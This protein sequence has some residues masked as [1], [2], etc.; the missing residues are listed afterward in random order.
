MLTSLHLSATTTP[1]PFFDYCLEN[2]LT[3][4]IVPNADIADGH[5]LP[6]PL[7]P[8][9][10]ALRNNGGYAGHE[11]I[12][13][14]AD[15]ETESLFFVF[16]HSTVRGMSQGGTRM[17]SYDSMQDLL[18][19]G[20][21]LSRAMTEKNAVAEIW[22]GG[23]KS[24]ICPLNGL[25]E[26]GSEQKKRIF[27]QFGSFVAALNGAYVAAEDM[28]TTPE[29]MHSILTRNRFVTCLP[30]RVGGSSNP[31]PWTAKG[32]FYAMKAAVKFRE[33]KNDLSGLTVL[34]QGVGN[35]GLSLAKHCAEAG[36]H[37]LA[38]DPNPRAQA[39]LKEAVPS[40]EIIDL[41]AVADTPCDI[42]APS[43]RGGVIDS[44]VAQR[45]QCRY[46]IGAA[47]NQLIQDTLQSAELAARD[48]LYLP[49]FYVNRMGIVNCAN[50]QYGYLEEDLQQAVDKIYSDTLQLL[51][52][53]REQRK[54]PYELAILEAKRLG[55]VPHPIWGHRGKR[56]LQKLISA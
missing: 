17:L 40:A 53:C 36:A 18:F 30:V 42:F 35:V 23:G 46:V 5:S 37:I 29:D 11:A 20:L 7:I 12:C 8:V 43:A 15:A 38:A 22:W 6:E 21:R 41:Q 32:V 14:A 47:N 2:G 55:A 16:I 13:F 54:T 45:L 19:D 31:S 3:R 49:D 4:G 34:I 27:E 10:E 50:E 44:A 39:A 1:R 33:N 28:N 52:T 48:I 24:I 9:A 56:I 51:H 26:P 25:P